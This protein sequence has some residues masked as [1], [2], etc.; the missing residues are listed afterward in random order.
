MGGFMRSKIIKDH[1]F[2][3]QHPQ[4]VPF[5]GALVMVVVGLP[6]PLALCAAEQVEGV[7]FRRGG[8]GGGRDVEQLCAGPHPTSVYPFFPFVLQSTL[9]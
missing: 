7:P 3:I 1:L 2:G 9:S 8:G 5:Y 6:N 4:N